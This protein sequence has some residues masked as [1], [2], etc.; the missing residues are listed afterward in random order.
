[1][2]FQRPFRYWSTSTKISFFRWYWGGSK[3]SRIPQFLR[4]S[5]IQSGH[6]KVTNCTSNMFILIRMWN[7]FLLYTYCTIKFV[8]LAVHSVV[9]KTAFSWYTDMICHS[10]F[11][12][13]NIDFDKQRKRLGKIQYLDIASLTDYNWIF[14]NCQHWLIEIVSFNV[15]MDF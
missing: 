7:N 14:C 9:A 13:G 4:I 5:L 2:N 1:M 10:D 15:E 8:Y 11:R 12:C 6:Y 3:I